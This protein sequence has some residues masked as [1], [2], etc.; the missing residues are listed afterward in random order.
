MVIAGDV[1]VCDGVTGEVEV[2]DEDHRRGGFLTEI[3]GDVGICGEDQERRRRYVS[4]F[5]GDVEV[6]GGERRRGG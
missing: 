2:Y 1:G 4:R 5:V 6:C 3:A